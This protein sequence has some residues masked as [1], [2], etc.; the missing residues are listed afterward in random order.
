MALQETYGNWLG[1]PPI[2]AKRMVR[3]A[4]KFGVKRLDFGCVFSFGGGGLAI[5]GAPGCAE[6]VGWSEVQLG[7][8]RRRSCF[9]KQKASRFCPFSP[10]SSTLGLKA[11]AAP[12][13]AAIASVLGIPPVILSIVFLPAFSF[14]QEFTLLLEK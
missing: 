3:Q 12:W 7:A 2:P 9:S 13:P 5:G 14:W 4:G 10:T 1:P 8:G 6:G 11:S